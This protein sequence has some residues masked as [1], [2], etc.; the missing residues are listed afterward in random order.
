MSMTRFWMYA[1][2][3]LMALAVLE[4]AKPAFAADHFYSVLYTMPHGRVVP[5]MPNYPPPSDFQLNEDGTFT[6]EA[7]F[8]IRAAANYR[9]DCLTFRCNPKEGP[10]GCMCKGM[11]SES[12]QMMPLVQNDVMSESK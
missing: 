6:G 5:R 7:P 3:M 8:A 4:G 9:S 10:A 1:L 2:M 12:G 11:Q